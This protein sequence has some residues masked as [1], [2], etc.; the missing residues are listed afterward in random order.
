MGRLSL[1]GHEYADQ[2]GDAEA[3]REITDH[4]RD[5]DVRDEEGCRYYESDHGNQ[6][7]QPR[8]LPIQISRLLQ[9]NPR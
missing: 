6:Q 2:E 5:I 4:G 9:E 3:G 1:P 8:F 7:E